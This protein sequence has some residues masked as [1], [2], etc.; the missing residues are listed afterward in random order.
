[1][2]QRGVAWETHHPRLSLPN[3]VL[4]KSKRNMTKENEQNLQMIQKE[5]RTHTPNMTTFLVF[6]EN[7]NVLNFTVFCQ[8]S[9]CCICLTFMQRN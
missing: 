7:H 9:I 3:N 6:L 2:E 5:G 1:M 4:Y 8:S